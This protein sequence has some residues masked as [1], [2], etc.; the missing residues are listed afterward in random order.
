MTLQRSKVKQI[1]CGVAPDAAPRPF[2]Q[3]TVWNDSSINF[4]V[5]TTVP[6]H[7]WKAARSAAGATCSL[8]NAALP[9]S[10]RG[11]FRIDRYQS[12]LWRYWIAKNPA[13]M[14]A[15]QPQ[16]DEEFRAKPDE[17]K[18]LVVPV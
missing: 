6:R 8:A 4:K 16:V 7:R 12:I 15:R 11:C 1:G 10:R 2:C 13:G 3:A 14:V 5:S 9:H 18:Y 17:E